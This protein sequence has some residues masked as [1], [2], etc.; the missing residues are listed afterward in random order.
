MTLAD[1]LGG[2]AGPV[3]TRMVYERRTLNYT[4]VDLLNAVISG[5]IQLDNDRAVVRTARF[6]IDPGALPDDF[7]VATDYI[8]P[9]MEVLVDG[10]FEAQAMGLFK[11]TKPKRTYE[12]NGRQLWD[13]EAQDV[14]TELLE[15]R[16]EQPTAG[17]A[18]G[19]NVITAIEARLDELGLSHSLPATAHNLP[20]TFIHAPGTDFLLI[21]NRMLQS[22]NFHPIWAD[23]EGSMTSKERTDPFVAAADVTYQT[24]EPPRMVREPFREIEER[25]R[26]PNKFVVL[27]D[28]PRRVPAFSLWENADPASPISTANRS[29]DLA[30]LTGEDGGGMVI[31]TT[32]A[33][34]IAEYELRDAAARVVQGDLNTAPDPRREPH[35]VYGLTIE[36]MVLG[37]PWLVLGWTLDLE[38][39]VT[40]QHRMGRAVDISIV[41]V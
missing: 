1:V 7:D 9:R 33:D 18:A 23:R 34:E 26:R 4:F 10:A 29:E 13:V 20:E 39:G 16:V 5:S 22:I 15:T 21:I 6:T 41:E 37:S 8:A 2:S 3:V 12:S 17:G 36:D 30:K 14:T 35:E 40:M 27:I 31:N 11:L 24:V 38:A 32:V 25:G 19:V 28:D